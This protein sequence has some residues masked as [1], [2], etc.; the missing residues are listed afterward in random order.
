M[1]EYL[2]GSLFRNKKNFFTA[3]PQTKILTKNRLC[4][5]KLCN[6]VIFTKPNL[7][8]IVLL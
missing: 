5:N 8:L 3:L 6:K 1:A 4:V 2:I 7:Y